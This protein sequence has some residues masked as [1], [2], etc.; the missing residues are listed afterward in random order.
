MKIHYEK[1]VDRRLKK[2]FSAS[3]ES[4]VSIDKLLG[5]LCHEEDQGGNR[6][7][8]IA[9]EIDRN[10]LDARIRDRRAK[11]ITQTYFPSAFAASR[12]LGYA[13]NEV[14]QA[15]HRRS[16]AGYTDATVAGVKFR[17]AD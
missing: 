17:W 14:A 5:E 10:V 3:E 15:L 2:R 9:W 11:P 8:V 4:A 16:K 6:R 13:H 7:A 12:H 1:R